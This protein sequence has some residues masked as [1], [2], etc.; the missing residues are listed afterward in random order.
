MSIVEQIRRSAE[1]VGDGAPEERRERETMLERLA[2]SRAKWWVGARDDVK[3][4]LG[5]NLPNESGEVGD[6]KPIN[7]LVGYHQ[8]LGLWKSK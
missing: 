7:L 2:A 6:V 3:G 1:K 5:P 8:L 4:I